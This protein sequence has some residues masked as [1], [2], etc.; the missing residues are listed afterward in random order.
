MLRYIASLAPQS[1]LYGSTLYDEAVVD[2]WLEMCVLEVEVAVMAAIEH[3]QVVEAAARAD[4][5]KTC[6]AL[7]KYLATRTYLAGERPTAAD[8]AIVCVLK[9]AFCELKMFAPSYLVATYGHLVR[10]YLTCAH[11]FSKEL[12]V[13]S[14]DAIE[15]ALPKRKALPLSAP[16]PNSKS[17]SAK[18]I[19]KEKAPSAAASP[20]E[21]A[22][23]FTPVFR[24]SR[25]RLKDLLSR[26]KEAIG[27]RGVVVKG[28]VRSVREAEKGATNFVELNDGSSLS[29]MQIVASRDSTANFETLKQ[30]G[31]AGASLEAVGDVV[32]SLG[33]GQVMELRATS[34]KILGA[35]RG[36]ENG[37][38]GAQYYP[39]AKKF[40]TPD[41]LRTHAHLRPRSRLG[42]A[43]VRIRHALAFATHEFFNRLGFLYIHTPLITAADCEGA[44]EQFT[45]TTLLPDE[46][47]RFVMPTTQSGSV[48][49]SKDFFG[50]KCGLTV[51]GQLNVETHAV[52]LADCYTFGPTF[53][54][55]N[56]HTS[57][58]LAE[59]WMIEPEISFA[60]LQDD[61]DLAQDYLK[62]CVAA[63]LARCDEDL[64]F[65]EQTAEKGLRDR[66]RAIV[67]T[68]RFTVLQYTDAIAMLQ[69]VQRDGKVNFE[70]KDIYW[71][72]DL[73]S[74]HERYLTEVVYGAPIVLVNY[75]KDIKAFYM[76]L[77]PV[78]DPS[79]QTVAAMDILVPKIGEIIGGSQ[80]EDD[81]ETLEQRATA[82]G[83]DPKS[84]SWYADLRRYGSVPHAG[85]GLGFERLIMLC[86]SVENIRDV[87]PF[88]R[89]PG[90]C[91]F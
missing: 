46:G 5:E 39:L 11:A 19:I 67:Q 28:W 70:N 88:P 23:L 51:S 84:I 14:F 71:G 65:F 52:S 3:G 68:E 34:V 54:A 12:G 42:S 74:E 57:R 63:V 22:S 24:R 41:H 56:S 40:H 72:M 20:V 62:Y 86:T 50:K 77:N 35:T 30:C 33:K 18:Q 89:Y 10:W 53:R 90:H 4:V 60:T 58:H 59:F 47:E 83:I 17:P 87:I 80:R 26:G 45:V 31:G 27:E 75:P 69:Q 66:L 82:V 15:A 73:N 85:F 91:D 76:K 79:K 6:K 32:E 7:D 44:G 1:E 78:T 16:S 29:S 13:A 43:V 61:I 81:L 8:V 21:P 9:T 36:G 25:T 37:T 49:Y 55:E 38:V 64:A 2:Q 48:D